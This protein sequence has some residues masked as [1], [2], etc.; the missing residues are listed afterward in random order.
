[1]KAQTSDESQPFENYENSIV[2]FD[3]MLLSK[4]ENNIDLFFTRGR[5]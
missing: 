4:E 1:M 3:V 5:H 2:F